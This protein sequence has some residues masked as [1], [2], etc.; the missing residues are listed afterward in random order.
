MESTQWVMNQSGPGCGLAAKTA[1]DPFSYASKTRFV[2]LSKEMEMDA[3][4]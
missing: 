4:N 2:V 1:G 3:A